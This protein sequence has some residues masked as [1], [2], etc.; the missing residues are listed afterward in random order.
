MLSSS[1]VGRQERVHLRNTQREA[2]GIATMWVPL[3]ANGG[4]YLAKGWVPN[5]LL[6]MVAAYT[7]MDTVHVQII[8][9]F[10]QALCIS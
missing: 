7:V 8:H 9:D 5:L 1:Y 2:H 3:L 10:T 6:N 4:E